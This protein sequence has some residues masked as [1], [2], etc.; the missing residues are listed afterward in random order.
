[1]NRARERKLDTLISA[2]Y[3]TQSVFY[4]Y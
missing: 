4:V 3:K 2:E 1:M